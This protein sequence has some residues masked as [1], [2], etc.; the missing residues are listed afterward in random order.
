MPTELPT[1]STASSRSVA[2]DSKTTA[3]PSAL[4]A[5]L[6]LGPFAGS[7]FAFA[8]RSRVTPFSRS[9][10]KTWKIPGSTCVSRRLPAADSKTTYRPS[11][12]MSGL[13]LA[14]LPGNPPGPTLSEGALTGCQIQHVDI[15]QMVA[16]GLDELRRRDE[17]DVT[18][19]AAH[20]G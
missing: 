17:D 2:V 15:P 11:R 6:K 19:A 5:G 13:R 12:L 4:M 8:E 1:V 3:V 14:P 16:V 9:R 10:R 20:A 18:P 7:P